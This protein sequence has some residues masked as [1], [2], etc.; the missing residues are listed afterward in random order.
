MLK[1]LP[2]SGGFFRR[3]K[4][5]A[6]ALKEF[7]AEYPG[8]LNRYVDAATISARDLRDELPERI[9]LKY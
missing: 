9:S 4:T 1:C 8:G 6:E 7:A 2:R 3:F 5:A